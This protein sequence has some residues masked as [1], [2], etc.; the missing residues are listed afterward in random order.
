MKTPWSWDEKQLLLQLIDQNQV[1]NR[2]DWNKISTLIKTRTA[3][4]CKLQYRNVLRTENVKVNFEWSD[5]QIRQLMVCVYFYGQKW[6]YIKSKYF[7][8]LDTEQLRLKHYQIRTKGQLY[9]KIVNKWV[10]TRQAIS[11][12]EQKALKFVYQGLSKLKMQINSAEQN[13]DAHDE[14]YINE[15]IQTNKQTLLH[16]SD[17]IKQCLDSQ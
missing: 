1:N 10:E 15:N 11:Q 5:E 7:P 8:F 9:E 12:N 4:Q 14:Q 2:I 3:I 17:K 6:K 13:S 16:I